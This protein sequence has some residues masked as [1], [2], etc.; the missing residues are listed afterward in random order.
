GPG[1]L[2]DELIATSIWTDQMVAEAGIPIID[3]PF[4]TVGGGFGSFILVD[5]LRIAGVPIEHIKVLTN[6][7][8]PYQ[9]YRFLCNNSQIPP[10]ER[11]RSDSGSCPD[12]IWA[13]PSYA[14]REAFREKAIKPLWNVFVEPDI[15]DFYTPRSGA[16]FEAVD[17]E[18]ARIR[19]PQMLQMGQVRMVRRRA[20]G[21]YF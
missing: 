19:W 20:G 14:V 13:F 12:N 2:T 3:S 15:A 1:D 5:F 21:G 8:V 16:V 18:A 17:R 11:L 4:V 9:T 7:Q 10:H 6:T